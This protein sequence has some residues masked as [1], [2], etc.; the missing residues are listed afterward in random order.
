MKALYLSRD[1][2]ANK[3][4]AMMLR[5]RMG[6]GP[7][8][9]MDTNDGGAEVLTVAGG[10]ATIR[11]RG[12][13][14]SSVDPWAGFFGEEQTAYGDIAE[15]L[16]HCA[17]DSTITGVELEID[18]PGGEAVGVADVADAVAL[19]AASKPVI[20]RISGLG[21]SAAYY[22]ASQARA[23]AANR[24]ALVGSVGVIM[25][26]HDVSAMYK[27][28]GVRPVVVA[29]GPDKAFLGVAG[30]PID[31]A[32]VANARTIVEPLFESFKHAVVRGRGIAAD[33]PVFGG[34]CY[35][36]K[37]A[38]N[39]NLIDFVGSA[40]DVRAWVHAQLAGSN[41]APAAQAASGK[42][43][44]N[45][46][47]NAHTNAALPATL[48]QLEAAFAGDSGFVLEQLKAKAT[49]EQAAVAKSKKLE[50]QLAQA[51]ADLAAKEIEISA[52][53]AHAKAGSGVPPLRS[54]GDAAAAGGEGNW[55]ACAEQIKGLVAAGKSRVDA[56]H[57]A[58]KSDPKGYAD[59]LHAR[60]CKI[61]GAN[62]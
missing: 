42:Q 48:D 19:L 62:F 18:S 51:R 31:D 21:C 29:S 25:V 15:A 34:A 27:E 43:T 32:I 54:G 47:T 50:Q 23:I 38:M 37:A 13:L 58:K 35:T 22:I 16:R 2:Y 9:S 33:S 44:M 28:M 7:V 45:D 56:E 46:S 1:W 5:A 4:T 39:A 57:E 8:V 52:L 41:H 36:A 3:V 6:L 24:D 60:R 12:T 40:S 11:V 10:I 14:V 17:A 26:M 30:E 53:K 61:D 59:L 20:A 55:K 49:M